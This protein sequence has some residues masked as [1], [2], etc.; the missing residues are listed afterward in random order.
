MCSVYAKVLKVFLNKSD[1][2]RHLSNIV[3]LNIGIHVLVCAFMCVYLYMA[4]GV[5]E[6]LAHAKQALITELHT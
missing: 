6:G 4:V 3:L 5:I 2:K 1:K